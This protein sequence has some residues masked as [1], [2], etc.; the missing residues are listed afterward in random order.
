MVQAITAIVFILFSTKF[1]SYSIMKIFK[2]STISINLYKFSLALLEVM[3]RINNV[4][5]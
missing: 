1:I 3:L 2:K 4:H 5:V